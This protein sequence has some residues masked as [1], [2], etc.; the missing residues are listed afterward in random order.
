MQIP[1]YIQARDEGKKAGLSA[2]GKGN[3]SKGGNTLRKDTLKNI[4]ISSIMTYRGKKGN[5]VNKVIF[6]LEL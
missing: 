1:Y 3:N 5:P 6:F 2:K 4:F